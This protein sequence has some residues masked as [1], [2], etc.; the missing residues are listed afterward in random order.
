MTERH[1]LSMD[2]HHWDGGAVYSA[3]HGAHVLGWSGV[4]IQVERAA[5]PKRRQ[6]SSTVEPRTPVT[7]DKC[8]Q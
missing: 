5:S 7:G 1:C 4:A 2:M 3:T 6:P 8:I